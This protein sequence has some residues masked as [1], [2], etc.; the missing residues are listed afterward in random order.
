MSYPVDIDDMPSHELR[1]ELTR[2]DWCLVNGRC[3]YCGQLLTTHTCKY[4]DD[5]TKYHK[6]EKSHEEEVLG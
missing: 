6:T 3:P 1:A 4:K 5:I 2:R